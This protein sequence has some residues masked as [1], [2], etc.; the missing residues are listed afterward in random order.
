[1]NPNEQSRINVAKQLN[2]EK[3]QKKDLDAAKL[4]LCKA[5]KDQ[6]EAIMKQLDNQEN[7]K[8]AKQDGIL[9]ATLV[10]AHT[11]ITRM[12]DGNEKE[13]K[14]NMIK[15]IKK[16]L[17]SN[18]KDDLKWRKQLF[19]CIEGKPKEEAIEAMFDFVIFESL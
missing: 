4:H 16:R 7:E 3:I 6:A 8:N 19:G 10:A 2:N 1:M 14:K 18:S 15:N 12:V 5:A 11:H 17:E 13:E 9:R